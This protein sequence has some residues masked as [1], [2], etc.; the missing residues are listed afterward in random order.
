MDYVYN[1][2]GRRAAGFEGGVA[3][4]VTRAYCVAARAAYAKT[5]DA[6]LA[7]APNAD[8]EGVNIFGHDFGVWMAANHWQF[9]PLHKPL[10]VREFP[11]LGR[12]IALTRNHV[13]AICDGRVEDVFD[14]R[15]ELVRGYWVKNLSGRFD[16]IN[17]L[18]T[19]LNRNGS[20]N[21]TQCI[22]MRDML[23]LNYNRNAWII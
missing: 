8:R 3:D 16:V 15:D 23:K 4:C 9:V 20:M 21:L 13:T 14:C 6:V 7:L 22:S 11:T 17:A 19:R 2:G 1:D 12:F 18:G 5:R 10:R